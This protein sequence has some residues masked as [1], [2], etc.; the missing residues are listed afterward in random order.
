MSKFTPMLTLAAVAS[1][2]MVASMPAQ[3]RSTVT[4]ATLDAAVASRPDSRAALTT[5]LSSKTAL[6]TAGR[7]GMSPQQLANRI[8]ALDDASAQRLADMV[9]GSTIVISTTAIIIAL[10]LII[11]LTR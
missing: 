10:L 2:T 8:A 4:T 7:M 3:T 1:I 6:A 11:I 5:A 9:G